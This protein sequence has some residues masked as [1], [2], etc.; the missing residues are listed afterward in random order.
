MRSFQEDYR[1]GLN[2]ETR[3][4][5][6]FNYYFDEEF[7]KTSP[8]HPFDFISTERFI[9][10]KSRTCLK[11]AYLTT[12]VGYDKIEAAKKSSK[13]VHF[14]FMFRDGSLW[15]IEY[16][17]EIFDKFEYQ[18]FQRDRRADHCDVRKQYCYIPVRLLEEVGR[19]VA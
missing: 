4:V 15:E 1:N 12:M 11:N 8:T 13:P 9:E 18:M 6:L 16:V 14:A 19:V 3:C 5:D 7:Q 17:P 2:N 10:L